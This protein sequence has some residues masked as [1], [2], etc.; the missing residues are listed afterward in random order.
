MDINF[1]QGILNIYSETKRLFDISGSLLRT[2]LPYHTLV[3]KSTILAIIIIS[4]CACVIIICFY[5]IGGN[6]SSS[7][8]PDFVQG[9]KM[10]SSENYLMHY[11]TALS[12]PEM[13]QLHIFLEVLIYL[14]NNLNDYILKNTGMMLCFTKLL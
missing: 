13:I 8:L 1:S 2:I 12:R 4:Y 3:H 6:F 11:Q 10:V 9:E 14:I 7:S 5:C